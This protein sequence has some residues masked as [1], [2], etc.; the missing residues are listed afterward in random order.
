[1][2]PG[3]DAL[4][5]LFAFDEAAATDQEILQR[6]VAA[7]LHGVAVQHGEAYVAGGRHALGCAAAGF[8][9][10]SVDLPAVPR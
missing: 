1:M 6:N 2:L 3:E 8:I 5:R 4:P 7:W 9:A 10:K